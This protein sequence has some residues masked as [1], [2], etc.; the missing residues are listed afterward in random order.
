MML[1]S[2]RSRMVAILAAAMLV[3]A[4]YA[5]VRAWTAWHEQTRREVD[6]LADAARIIAA[7]QD[8]QIEATF[9]LLAELA[10]HSMVRSMQMP[11]CAELLHTTV[12]QNR[13]LLNI[14]L[15]DVDGIIRCGSSRDAIGISVADR[16]YFRRIIAGEDRVASEV[17]IVRTTGRR[18]FIVG[19][20]IRG[21]GGEVQAALVASFEIAR[22]SSVPER[23]RIASDAA[24]LLLDREGVSLRAPDA[25]DAASAPSP[26]VIARLREAPGSS[27]RAQLPDGRSWLYVLYP[28]GVGG[29]AVVVGVPGRAWA[30]LDADLLARIAAPTLLLL[31]ALAVIWLAL[32]RL[33]VR[34]LT[35]LAAVA[36]RYRGGELEAVPELDGA[37]AEID[38]LGRTMAQM[39][40][41]LA[42]REQA[43][44][45]SLAQKELLLREIH[46]RVK[47]NLQIVTSLLNL[48]AGRLG[49]PI[50]REA[51]A[52][53]QTRIKALALVHRHLYEQSEVG[54]V[55]LSAFV[56]DLCGTLADAVLP[57][58]SDVSLSCESDPLTVP[59]E[60]AISLSLLIAEALS[61]AFK[62]GFPDGRAGRVEVRIAMIEDGARAR[63][64][65][66]DDGVG[67]AEETRRSGLGMTLIEMLAR[68][69]GGE[70][71]I[72]TGSAGTALSVTFV[73]GALI[74]GAVA[75]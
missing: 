49:S 72:E 64:S 24:V 22:F 5:T 43:L 20:P 50:A 19:R 27:V 1:T 16:E 30:W 8:E 18:S 34:H 2:L 66:R 74:R 58:E 57:A 51:L 28:L 6:G 39:A 15:A 36:Q 4:T 53:A 60:Q 70:L 52:E 11:A 41:A 31:I 71:A 12:R 75:A 54:A 38:A 32:D 67:I 45:A 44:S 62:H 47:N 33:V 56:D 26:E 68:Q 42:E 10:T 48:R 63:L 9:E 23:V 40:G 37:P 25:E 65:I 17:L 21:E 14:A 29:F 73:P 69:A 3:P 61:N 55:D 35:A 7:Y 13:I 59:A 46:H